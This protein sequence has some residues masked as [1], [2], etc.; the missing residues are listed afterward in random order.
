MLA[1]NV[2]L[3]MQVCTMVS[4]VMTPPLGRDSSVNIDGLILGYAYVL[5]MRINI[6]LKEKTLGA[7]L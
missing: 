4:A 7:K 2:P 3:A 6:I 5:L 1:V